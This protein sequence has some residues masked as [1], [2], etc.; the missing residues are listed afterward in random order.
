M[1]RVGRARA[2]RHALAL[3]CTRAVAVAAARSELGDPANVALFAKLPEVTRKAGPLPSYEWLVEH[4]VIRHDPK[5]HTT[6]SM[7]QRVFT[8]IQGYEPPL[9]GAKVQAAGTPGTSLFRKL[10]QWLTGFEREIMTA[11]LAEQTSSAEIL[12]RVPNVPLGVYLHGGVGTGKSFLMDLFYTCVDVPRRRRVHF[13]AFMLDVHQQLHRMRQ[14]SHGADAVVGVARKLSDDAWL[15]CFDEFQVTD[16]ADAMIIRRLFEHMFAN[17]V[18]VVATSNRKPADLYKNGLQRQLFV[19]FIAELEH[20]CMVHDIDSAVDYR[21]RGTVLE[22]CFLVGASTT[23]LDE[24]FALATHNMPAA[25]ASLSVMGHTLRVPKAA[26]GVARFHFTDLC[27]A[28]VGAADYIALSRR[29]HTLILDSIPQLSADQRS[30]ARRLITLIDVLYEH[31]VRLVCSSDVPLERVFV[32][33]GADDAPTSGAA[34]QAAA[35]ERSAA[36]RQLM[37]DLGLTEADTGSSIFTGEDEM[38]AFSRALSRLAEMQ[39]SEYLDTAGE[40]RPP[41]LTEAHQ[42]A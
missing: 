8:D 27:A 21:R 12:E 42:A 14:Q 39:T 20:A 11:S 32:G 35:R 37:D 1:L 3:P 25:P 7:L 40:K 2:V 31:R 41:Q 4:E 15:L 22:H 18:V 24:V 28:A 10:G 38:F 33:G 23:L 36:Q 6:A 26:G 34:A 30:E 13:H 16:V 29:Y 17:G 5:Q 9:G 19:P